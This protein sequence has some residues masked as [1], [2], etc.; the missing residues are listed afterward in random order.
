MSGRQ[1]LRDSDM[2]GATLGEEIEAGPDTERLRR[3]DLIFWRG[4]VAVCQGDVG[5]VAHIIHASGFTMNVASEPLDEAIERIAYLY[6]RPIGFRSLS[7]RAG[8]S[9]HGQGGS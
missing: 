1:V 9:S 6:E 3:G 4:H 7:G 2:Q 8:K 5:G